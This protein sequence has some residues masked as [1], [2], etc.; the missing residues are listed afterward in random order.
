MAPRGRCRFI[1]VLLELLASA[2]AV[3]TAARAEPVRLDTSFELKTLWAVFHDYGEMPLFPG[4]LSIPSQQARWMVDLQKDWFSAEAHLVFSLATWNTDNQVF[5]LTGTDLVV[6]RVTETLPLQAELADVP[7]QA[8]GNHIESRLRFDRLWLRSSTRHFDLTLGRQPLSFGTAVIYQI[9]DRI[10]PLPPFS[11]DREYKPGVDAIRADVHLAPATDL[12]LVYA[13][14]GD[15]SAHNAR[16]AAALRGPVGAGEGLLFASVLHDMPLFGLGYE[17]DLGSWILRG[18][19]SV[20]AESNAEATAPAFAMATLGFEHA[21]SFGLNLVGE[22]NYFGFGVTDPKDYPKVLYHPRILSGDLPFFFGSFFAGTIAS[23]SFLSWL[24]ASTLIS[25]SL[26]DGSVYLYPT[27]TC[28][29]PRAQFLL[30]SIIPLGARGQHPY[31]P[32]NELDL[33]PPGVLM[34]LRVFFGR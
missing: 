33:S 15:A 22:L 27:I 11:I 2:P 31:Q 17:V 34:E 20:V 26:L 10:V 16:I 13:F 29:L 1:L 28:S 24:D 30:S 5:Q 14:G 7:G 23:Y 32:N 9:I 21:F 25:V 12:A 19:G 8:G 4:T 6:T 18:E 3:P